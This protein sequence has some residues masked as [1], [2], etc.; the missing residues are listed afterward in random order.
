MNKILKGVVICIGS[1][2]L[3]GC[4]F[5]SVDTVDI[6]H[7]EKYCKEE[8]G[9]SLRNIREY[10]TGGTD[11]FCENGDYLPNLASYK[12]AQ[13]RLQVEKGDL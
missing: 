7:A 11:V 2:S 4:L 12:N 9:S 3:A 8:R 5:Q 1:L 6:Y 10:F 13:L